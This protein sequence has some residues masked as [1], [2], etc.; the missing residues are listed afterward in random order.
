[1]ERVIALE[2]MPESE[3]TLEIEVLEVKRSRLLT[4]GVRWPDRLTLSAPTGTPGNP[5]TLE[6]LRRLSD[7]Q[8][9]AAIS[10]LVID[11]HQQDSDTNLLANPL[12]RVRNREKA[13]IMIGDK[14][15][16]VTTTASA[17]GFVGEN[18]TYLDVG[19]KVE[20]EPQIDREDEVAIKV[21]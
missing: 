17:T 3:V 1:A 18:I 13:K 16:V 2:D 11:L 14:V 4:L 19:L 6:D 7:G 21:N 8:I 15:P 12:V 9:N 20:V 10:D 5:F